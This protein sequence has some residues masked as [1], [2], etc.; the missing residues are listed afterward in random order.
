MIELLDL[1]FSRRWQTNKIESD[2][3]NSPRQLSSRQFRSSRRI[4]EEK[5]EASWLGS[6]KFN[7]SKTLPCKWVNL[8]N[9]KIRLH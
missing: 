9:Y 6:N 7:T 8:T 4:T 5:S 2:W 3:S 1:K